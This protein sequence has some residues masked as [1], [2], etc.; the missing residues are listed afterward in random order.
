M[1]NKHNADRRH[2]IAKMKMKV[3]NWSEYNTGLRRRGS[4]TLWVT[5]EAVADWQAQPRLTRGGRPLYSDTAIET[6]LMLR[7]AFRMPLRQ[8]EGLMGLV[9][10][11]LGVDLSV[12][13]YSTVSRRAM[14][15]CRVV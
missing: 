9:F 12:P 3:T 4:M 7:S 1:P 13:D 10:Q 2:H 6:S 14:R 11:L 8:A 15:F 5:D